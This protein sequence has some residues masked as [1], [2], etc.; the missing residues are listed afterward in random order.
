MSAALWVI[1]AAARFWEDA[2]E[3]EPFP[4]ALHRP[5]AMALPL[6]VVLLPRLRVA[7]IDA[8]LRE[9]G[10][11]CGIAAADRPLRACLVARSG[12]GLL[13]VDGTDREDERRFSLAHE[14]AHF[15]RHYAGP[16]ERAGA[17]LGLEILQVLDGRRAP[18]HQERAH[19]LLAGLQIGYHVHLME[20]RGGAATAAVS[21]AERE[22]D[23]L[24][25]ELLAPTSELE[26]MALS[27]APDVR[28]GRIAERLERHY[29]MPPAQAGQYAATLVPRPRQGS[30]LLR[31]L[32]GTP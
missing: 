13:F 1:E 18:T 10:V 24:A 17:V 2:G 14:L 22:A 31:A 19:A 8:W 16:R 7:A 23:A 6:A 20:R 3:E 27:Y 26:A 4:R 15:L 12:Q 29:G 11:P 32:R 30:S 5:I 28:R 9:Q 21:A 25:F